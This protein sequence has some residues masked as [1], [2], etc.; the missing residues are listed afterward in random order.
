MPVKES[1][2]L[3]LGNRQVVL[4]RRTYDSLQPWF[5]LRLH[6]NET[7]AGRAA[8]AFLERKGGRLLEVDNGG[9]RNISF[10][11]EGRQFTF[12]PNRMFTPAGIAASLGLYSTFLPAA[13][14]EV[15]KL[16]AFVLAQL[17]DSATVVAVHNNTDN[18]YSILSY[19]EDTAYRNDAAHL[20]I[21]YSL[22]ADNFFLTTDSTV[23]HYLKE[24]N[25]NVVLQHNG[26]AR[27]DGSLSVW[28]GRQNRRYVNVEAQFGHL[29]AQTEMLHVLERLF[30][31]L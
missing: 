10:G 6:H 1:L 3:S 22:D 5:L 24:L 8:A 21:N 23:F 9:G 20:H 19:V 13:A 26:A 17:P 27:D 18:H 15:E 30:R 28:M 12:D 4:E 16:G 29:E 25:Y 14:A 11:L 2:S 31:R 7:T